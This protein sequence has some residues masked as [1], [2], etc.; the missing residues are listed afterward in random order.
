M[1]CFLF[2]VVFSLFQEVPFK[3]NAEFEIKV[4]YQFKQRPASEVNTLHLGV[5]GRNLQRTSLGVLPYLVLHIKL[6][7]LPHEKTRMTIVTN[8]DGR[9]VYKKISVNSVY[10][11][12]MGFTVDMTDRVT[13]HEYT[14]TFL[15]EDKKPLNRIHISIDEDGSFVVNGEKRGQI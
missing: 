13:A 3:P 2:L 15:D 4:D 5:A 14:L 10:E 1:T 6:L 12:D 8:L 7:A 11:L 9:A